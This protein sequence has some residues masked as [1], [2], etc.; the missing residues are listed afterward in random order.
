M[1]PTTPE[2]IMAVVASLELKIAPHVQDKWAASALR[3]AAQLLK[4]VALR[5]ESEAR[6][7]G[8]DNR[9]VREVLRTALPRLAAHDELSAL[10]EVVESALAGPLPDAADTAALDVR[11]EAYQAAVEKLLGSAPV[12]ALDG[13]AVHRSLRDYLRRRLEREHALY[14]PVFTGPP[15]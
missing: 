14:F 15:F 1:R 12:R 10:R 11:N 2:L 13:A 9:D 7:L 8:E 6:V 4:H 5:T 3:S